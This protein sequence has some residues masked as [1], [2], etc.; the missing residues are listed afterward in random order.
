MVKIAVMMGFGLAVMPV[1]FG[2]GG[3]YSRGGVTSTGA[4]Q[5]FEPKE[6]GKVRIM[7]ETLKVTL[8]PKAA[9]VEIR[10]IMRNLTDSTARVRFGFP[11]EESVGTDPNNLDQKKSNTVNG[12]RAV[13]QYCN[14]YHI[15]VGGKQVTANFEAEKDT[16]KDFKGIA[17]W[18]VSEAKFDKGEEKTLNIRFTSVYPLYH[19][20]ISEDYQS[21]GS[22][23]FY[24]LS[25][26]AC[27]AGT[28]RHGTVVLIPS[29]IDPTELAVI[30]PANRFHKDG[31]NWV[32][33]FEELEPTRADDMEIQ[34]APVETGYGRHVGGGFEGKEPRVN[35]VQRGKQWEMEH[36]FY[37]VKASSTLAPQDG[38]KYDAD[39]L[40]AWD[41]VWSEGAPGSGAGEW[42]EIRPD[43]P[44]PL[45]A[46]TLHPGFSR[47]E[48]LFHANARPKSVHIELN[49]EQRFDAVIPDRME[50]C[51]IP[52]V[53]YAK[54]VSKIKL[55]FASV[56]EGKTYQDMCIASI[57]LNAVLAKKPHIQPCR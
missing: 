39:N 31:A 34:A 32:W 38:H 19:S 44:Q 18:L 48:G 24:R 27:W 29:G 22:S 28:I 49:G 12:K 16:S 17:G 41:G 13:P 7:D 36:A 15:E 47:N 6:T 3:G 26:G 25:T 43:V 53:G 55:T 9:E 46:I 56:Y 14:G 33:N 52:V 45:R 23:F 2:N 37:R 21:S 51:R 20:Y 10:Y 54:P 5:G 42:L 50:E 35:Y 40:K 1:A 4:V 30:K 8:G 11:V 57:R